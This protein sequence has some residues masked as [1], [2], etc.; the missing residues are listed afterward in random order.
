MDF[1]PD[2]PMFQTVDSFDFGFNQ[3]PALQEFNPTQALYLSVDNIYRTNYAH[4][5]Q[6]GGADRLADAR[7]GEKDQSTTRFENYG[8]VRSIDLPGRMIE[9]KSASDAGYL[10]LDESD[11]RQFVSRDQPPMSLGLWHNKLGQDSVQGLREVFSKPPHNL[12]DDEYF[13]IS[14]MMLPGPWSGN[15]RNHEI[16]LSTIEINGKK[17]IVYDCWRTKDMQR[18]S[19]DVKPLPED[20]RVRV[21]M[22]PNEATGKVD[23]VWMQSSFADFDKAK[24]KFD[25]SLK[26]IKWK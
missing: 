10:N 20:Q 2:Q 4:M 13:K 18:D 11:P 16:G 1:N 7:M 22:F 23:V 5:F 21:V 25:T 26:S 19:F 14:G 15:G 8:S 12:S 9:Q 6:E 3:E 24:D 17:A